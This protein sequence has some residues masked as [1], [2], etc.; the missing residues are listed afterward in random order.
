MQFGNLIARMRA[1]HIP[2]GTED[3]VILRPVGSLGAIVFTS[4]EV[5]AALNQFEALALT[6]SVAGVSPLEKLGIRLLV[7]STANRE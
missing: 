2:Q 7:E 5:D 1:Q 3:A 6:A 4:N